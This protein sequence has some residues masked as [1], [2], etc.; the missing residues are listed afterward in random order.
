RCVAKRN[1][2]GATLAFTGAWHHGLYRR[3]R[4]RSAAEIREPA[5]YHR[6]PANGR[7][8][9]GGRPF[10]VGQDVSSSSSEKRARNEAGG[11][12]AAALFGGG[13]TCIGRAASCGA[14][15]DGHSK[16]RRT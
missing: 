14:R 2:G 15:A 1:G 6:R 13:K 9:R 5:P 10:W 16:G 8:E 12:R 11:R 3:G 7:D 4:G